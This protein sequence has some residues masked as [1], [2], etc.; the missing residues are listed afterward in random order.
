MEGVDVL[1]CCVIGVKCCC[2]CSPIGF[3]YDLQI[4]EVSDRE[5]SSP[6]ALAICGSSLSSPRMAIVVAGR[7]DRTSGVRCPVLLLMLSVLDDD[8][9]VLAL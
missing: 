4:K 7:C 8:N 6:P 5:A 9:V 1:R 3:G 2:C